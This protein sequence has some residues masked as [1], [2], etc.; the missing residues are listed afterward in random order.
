MFKKYGLWLTLSIA[1]ALTACG[2]HLRGA[3]NLP[4]ALHWIYLSSANPYGAVTLQLKQLLKQ[5]QVVLEDKPSPE[6][7]TLV[8][9]NENSYNSTF[10]Q[11]ASSKTVQYTL[12]YTMDYS[13]QDSKGKTLYGPKTISTQ[14]NYTVNE[15][16]ILTSSTQE[17]TTR[18]D[19]QKRIVYLL[20]DQLSSQNVTKAL[21]LPEKSSNEN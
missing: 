12:H 20:L 5:S 13:L 8:L 17:N 16:A 21:T 3:V 11:S 14:E 10:S 7:I 19:L 18:E 2:F 4:K 1:I 9:N 6:A 15:D